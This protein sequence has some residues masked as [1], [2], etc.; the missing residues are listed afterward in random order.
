MAPI[1]CRAQRVRQQ[2]RPL[3]ASRAVMVA[4]SIATITARLERG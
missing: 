3:L 1:F 2:A 4:V